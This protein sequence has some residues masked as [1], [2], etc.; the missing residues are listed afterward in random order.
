M[1]N[2]NNKLIYTNIIDVNN[3][4]FNEWVCKIERLGNISNDTYK[5]DVNSFFISQFEY[6]QINNKIQD[7]IQLFKFENLHELEIEY[8]ITLPYLNNSNISHNYRSVYN[9]YSLN[10]VYNKY[11]N[12]FIKFNYEKHL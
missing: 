3:L 6:L 7:S 10:Y 9:E 5:D 12:D 8:N 2:L 11:F 4:D 1:K